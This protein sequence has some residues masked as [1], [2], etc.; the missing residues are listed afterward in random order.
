MLG[1]GA[2]SR[3]ARAL[4]VSMLAVS[5]LALVGCQTTPAPPIELA[6]PPP[7]AAREP[8]VPLR[9]GLAFEKGFA[10]RSFYAMA[11]QGRSA[12]QVN[13]G[14]AQRSAFEAAMRGAFAEIVMLDTPDATIGRPVDAIITIDMLS[15]REL[16]TQEFGEASLSLTTA[17]AVFEFQYQVVLA[18]AGRNELARWSFFGRGDP[19]IA[20]A[21]ADYWAPA[22]SKAMAQAVERVAAILPV[23]PEV[24]T[25]AAPPPATAPTPV[26]IA[27]GAAIEAPPMSPRPSPTFLVIPIEIRNPGPGRVLLR[28]EDAVVT[29]RDS[30][31]VAVAEHPLAFEP[32]LRRFAESLPQVHS[33][34]RGTGFSQPGSLLGEIIFNLVDI[35][36]TAP[37]RARLD[38]ALAPARGA[39]LRDLW[40]APGEEARVYGLFTAPVAGDRV[41][42]VGLRISTIDLDRAERVTVELPVTVT[43]AP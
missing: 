33:Y 27:G 24:A 36:A 11:A 14:A 22:I 32:P 37:E 4:L 12:G 38:S 26:V 5:A 16:K 25:R 3:A 18:D 34:H 40:L 9:V 30:T 17:T 13:F 43:L 19:E 31:V 42:R 41:E 6:A 20:F 15:G 8:R 28:E 39:L 2:H 7:P 10:F 1:V 21:T 35:A 23:V 29:V